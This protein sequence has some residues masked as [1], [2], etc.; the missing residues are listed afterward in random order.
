MGHANPAHCEVPEE[1]VVPFGLKGVH[2]VS[3]ARRRNF[4][5]SFIAEIFA[6][7]K[8]WNLPFSWISFLYL[9]TT[10]EA[11]MAARNALLK[12]LRVNVNALPQ[13]QNPRAGSGG[14]SQLIRRHF[15]DEMRGSFLDKSEVTDRVLNVVKN[16]QKVEPSKVKLFDYMVISLVIFHLFIFCS[17][18]DWFGYLP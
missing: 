1:H 16:F 4:L 14:L 5:A 11:E 10:P 7:I 8:L 12:Y 2:F 18:G 15:S 17:Y 3:L 13:L 9:N 6:I